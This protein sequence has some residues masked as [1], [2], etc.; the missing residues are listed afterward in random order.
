MTAGN[1]REIPRTPLSGIDVVVVGG[2]LGGLVAAVELFRKGH[3]VKVLEARSGI[4]DIGILVHHFISLTGLILDIGDF[5]GI[6]LSAMRQFEKWPDMSAIYESILY[7][8]AF[9]MYK[10]DGEF[11]GG[12]YK[13]GYGWPP[14]PVARPKL[15]HALFNYV[16]SLGIQVL[17][18]KR[19]V[20]YSEDLEKNKASVVTDIG[21]R[22]EADLV[23]AADGIGTKSW[24][25]TL[26]AP[27][28]PKSSGYAVYRTAFPTKIAFQNPKVAET[29]AIPEDGEDVGRLYLG[30]KTHL[31]ILVN[32]DITTWLLTHQVKE[33]FVTNY[34][35]NL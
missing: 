8:P 12:P 26:G 6:G 7:K 10:I 15:H 18:S 2:G 31:I 28:K 20:E 4:E 27:E 22:F 34:L 29:F 35:T 1:I 9:S 30:P 23:I 11:L 25:I 24:P 5:I 3:N 21:D 13:D 33:Q 16:R 17:F 19:V 14:P 32:K